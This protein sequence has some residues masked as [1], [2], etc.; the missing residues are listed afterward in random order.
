[1]QTPLQHAPAQNTEPVASADLVVLELNV[2]HREAAVGVLAEKLYAA[3]RIENL[4]KFLTEVDRREHQL[5][6]GLPGGIG[7]AHARSETTTQTSIAVGVV[8]FGKGIDFGAVDGAAQVVLLLATPATSYSAH[9]NMLAA[10]ARS[11]SKDSF[12][13]SL[14]R[15]HDAE[16][17]AELINSTIDFSTV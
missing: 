15:A 7:I 17:I 14:R 10:L 5:A 8:A 4:E 13:T 2:P 1:M 12:R 9:L 11:L 6:T 3:S 16:V